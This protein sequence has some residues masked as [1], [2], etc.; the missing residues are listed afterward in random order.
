[1]DIYTFYALF[2]FHKF[3]NGVL[4]K[5]KGCFYWLSKK[6]NKEQAEEIEKTFKNVIILKGTNEFAP[7]IC[8]NVVFLS[9]TKF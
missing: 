3:K 6:L 1:M 4:R 5:K 2:D 8:S 7:E 9:K